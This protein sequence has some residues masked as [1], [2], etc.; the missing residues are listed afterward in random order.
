MDGTTPPHLH[1][2]GVRSKT[3]PATMPS[4]GETSPR[5]TIPDG[6]HSPLRHHTRTQSLGP[7]EVKETLDACVQYGD[8][9]SGQGMRLN[10]YTIKQEIG[11]GS[12]G[13]VHLAVDQTGQTYAIKEFSKSRLRKRSQ[14]NI[15]RRPHMARSRLTYPL[16]THRRSASQ[17]H[18]DESNG[19]PLYLIREEIAIMKKLD[20]E[21]IIKLYEVLDDPD[22]DS[23]YMVM[24]M[25]SKGVVMKMGLGEKADPYPEEQCRLW[26]RDMI[27]GIE[28][29]HSQGIIHRD[30]KPDNLLLTE[31]DCL[32]IVDFG[33]SEMFKKG[34]E[35]FTA[36]SA[37]SPA[38]IPPELCKVG[39]GDVSGEAADIWSMGATLYCLCFGCLP[40]NHS[41]VLELYNAIKND[42]PEIPTNNPD[43]KD[44]ILCLLDKNPKTRIKMCQLRVHPWVTRHGTDM[45]LSYEENTTEILIP[46]EEEVNHA[47][48][49][50]IRH[51]MTIVKALNKLKRLTAKKR[52]QRKMYPSAGRSEAVPPLAEHPLKRSKSLDGEQRGPPGQHLSAEGVHP[53]PVVDQS[54]DTI[55]VVVAPP[56]RMDSA[57]A[58]EDGEGSDGG[59]KEHKQG[60]SLSPLKAPVPF[61]SIGVGGNGD[62]E[63][64]CVVSESP[65]GTDENLYEEAYQRE[66]D[67][68]REKGKVPYGTALAEARTGGMSSSFAKQ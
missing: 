6:Y 47:I 7:R 32:K 41:G 65:T 50:S 42:T 51:V 54:R 46:T 63:D 25:C 52:A 11:R 20:H 45:L 16:V 30:I 28:Y 33:V 38:F 8:E 64:G 67:K 37:G 53:E 31:D 58:L 17:V 2:A 60:Q 15:L 13:A 61:L 56:K 68:I 12:F 23:L 59:D 26:F 22:G 55:L 62:N 14:S 44:L 1:S 3:F 36:K 48:T 19:K 10:Q 43:L 5:S 57:V 24:E 29:L 21:N 39:H 34:T 9:D 27:L 35:M 66:V 49:K 18:E 4:C 40:F